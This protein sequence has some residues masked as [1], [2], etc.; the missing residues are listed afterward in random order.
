MP[1]ETENFIAKIENVPEFCAEIVAYYVDGNGRKVGE[2]LPVTI[3]ENNGQRTG[4][5]EVELGKKI[6][7]R[8]VSKQLGPYTDW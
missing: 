1:S 8:Y 7:V 6:G 3:T 5:F 2:N 4:T